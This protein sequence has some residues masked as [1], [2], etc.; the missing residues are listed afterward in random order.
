MASFIDSFEVPVAVTID[1]KEVSL[2]PLR[3]GDYLVWC[4]EVQKRYQDRN[5]PL[6][7]NIAKPAERMIAESQIR[8][9]E[10]TPDDLRPLV[11]TVEGIQRI[12][13][14]AIV[15]ALTGQKLNGNV[16]DP[17]IAEAQ[18]KADEFIDG[19]SAKDA[20]ALSMRLS[21][22]YLQDEIDDWYRIALR[23]KKKAGEPPPNAG[24][25][26]PAALTVAQ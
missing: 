20:E 14:G 13:R 4:A 25:G 2:S 1:G 24:A 3:I 17:A 8:S 26:Q 19:L 11:F 23:A 5:L 10:F 18:A 22:L 12:I 15:R 6:L 7:T 16:S 21:G 9:R